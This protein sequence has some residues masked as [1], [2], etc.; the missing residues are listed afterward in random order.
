MQHPGLC[1]LL[2]KINKQLLL[3][4]YYCS[5]LQCENMKGRREAD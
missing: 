3:N 2:K 1:V 5:E 4:S